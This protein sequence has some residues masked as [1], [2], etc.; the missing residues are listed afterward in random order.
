[1]W[2]GSPLGGRTV[3]LHAEQGLGDTIHFVRY[4]PLVRARGGEV[5][6]ACPR[7]LRPLL[8]D[9][10]ALGRLAVQGEEPPPFDVY[11]PL[12]SLPALLG[13]TL[14]TVPAD[15]PYLHADA[16]LVERWRR[17]LEGVPGFKVGLVWQG[18]PDHR[19]DSHRSVPLRHFA[20]LARVPGV[21]LLSLQKG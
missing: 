18:N 9:A 13:T 7:A 21:S 6:V 12:M 2:D 11:A 4:A 5:V 8:A 20:T 15:V 3:L 19:S 10:P 14:A 16:G 17:E 1:A